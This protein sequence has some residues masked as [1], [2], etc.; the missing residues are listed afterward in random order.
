MAASFLLCEWAASVAPHPLLNRVARSGAS[1]NQAEADAPAT[2]KP[3]TGSLDEAMTEPFIPRLAFEDVFLALAVTCFV[4]VFFAGAAATVT[5]L[6]RVFFA[7]TF[8]TVAVLPAAFLPAVPFAARFFATGVTAI[9]LGDALSP[10]ASIRNFERSLTSLIH[11]GGRAQPLH[12]SPVFGLR[13]LAGSL[14][15]PVA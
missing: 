5:G 6:A 11:A 8:F 4:A 13:Y 14:P 3:V 12:V 1:L 15:L 2:D 10:L 7:A 9:S